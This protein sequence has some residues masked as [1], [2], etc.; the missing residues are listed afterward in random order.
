M[1]NDCGLV[2]VTERPDM[3]LDRGR[4]WT[5]FVTIPRATS[6][7]TAPTSRR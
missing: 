2:W 6:N 4:V 7:H 5:R 3:M 1:P